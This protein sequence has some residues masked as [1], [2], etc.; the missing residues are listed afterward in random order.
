[1]DVA[2]EQAGYM[3]FGFGPRA[4]VGKSLAYAEMKIVL[5]RLIFEFA[6]RLSETAK[7]V[8]H[9]KLD[10][11]VASCKDEFKIFDSFIAITDGPIV[12]FKSSL[13]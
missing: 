8:H 1:M 7:T 10:S 13:A 11:R 12:E 3:P 2:R 4:C 5:A 6:M 9:F